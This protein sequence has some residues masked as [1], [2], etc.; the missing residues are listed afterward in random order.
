M[1]PEGLIVY[2]GEN[3][4]ITP[5][6]E[7]VED[8]DQE[9]A[10][11]PEKLQEAQAIKDELAVAGARMSVYEADYDETDGVTIGN[12]IFVHSPVEETVNPDKYISSATG[13]DYGDFG[14]VSDDLGV[15]SDA[16]TTAT[17]N[18]AAAADYPAI[19]ELVGAEEEE[20]DDRVVEAYIN[21][22][23]WVEGED[24]DTANSMIQGEFEIT[25]DLYALAHNA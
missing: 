10:T 25:L 4:K 13:D 12:K 18:I 14:T 17:T 19:A 21:F 11:E 16:F 2:L 7:R 5:V 1:S 8:Y 20:E 6:T 22:R 15:L 9:E 3:T 24:D 23:F